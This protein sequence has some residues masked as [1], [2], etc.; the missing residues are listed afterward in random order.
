MVRELITGTGF[1]TVEDRHRMYRLA[2]PVAGRIDGEV[3]VDPKDSC[4]IR[5]RWLFAAF[6]A[7]LQVA[8]PALAERIVLVNEAIELRFDTGPRHD[9]LK[10]K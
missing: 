2:G 3:H 8:A 4:S 10:L 6:C 1:P 5:R 7:L 9:R